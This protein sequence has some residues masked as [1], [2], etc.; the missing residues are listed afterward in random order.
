M[1]KMKIIRIGKNTFSEEY[2]DK[3]LS[4]GRVNAFEN[5]LISI[6]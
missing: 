2:F 4:H 5:N 1:K 6:T 3:T